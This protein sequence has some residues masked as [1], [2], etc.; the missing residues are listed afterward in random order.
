MDSGKLF[1]E[2]IN[3]G[4]YLLIL[5]AA[6]LNRQFKFIDPYDLGDLGSYVYILFSYTVLSHLL[7]FMMMVI[8]FILM[9]KRALEKEPIEN[10]FALV[11]FSLVHTLLFYVTLTVIVPEF[12]AA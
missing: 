12:I 10:S 7:S 2:K 8:G 6:V 5:F 4:L 9:L 11:K 3:I 1:I